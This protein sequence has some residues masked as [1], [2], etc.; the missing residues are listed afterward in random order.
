MLLHPQ[1]VNFLG[2]H[3][4]STFL[5]RIDKVSAKLNFLVMMGITK[6]LNHKNDVYYTV[7]LKIDHDFNTRNR[8]KY[9][10]PVLSWYL[11]TLCACLVFLWPW[12]LISGM[13]CRLPLREGLGSAVACEGCLEDGLLEQ[14]CLNSSLRPSGAPFIFCVFHFLTP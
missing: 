9:I 3:L 4:D 10:T 6:Y 12:P 1:I 11:L 2:I 5:T 8:S 7:T 14:D 13:K